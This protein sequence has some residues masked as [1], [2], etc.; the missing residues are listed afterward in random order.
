LLFNIRYYVKLHL[1]GSPVIPSKIGEGNN[2]VLNSLTYDQYGKGHCDSGYE[3]SHS[4]YP[5]VK[6]DDMLNEISSNSDSDAIMSDMG[7][8]SDG[9]S[10]VI[11]NGYL[12]G[13]DMTG[14]I[15]WRHIQFCIIQNPEPRHPNILI[16]IVTL[17]YIKGEDQ[18][19]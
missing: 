12:A 13:D 10:V 3:L 9:S 4:G 18:K 8:I 17:I 5:N 6:E 7:Y 1:D 2:R 15:L 16:A 11:D 19:P 14:T